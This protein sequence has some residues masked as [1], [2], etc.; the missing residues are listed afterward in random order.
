[1]P[2]YY[3]YGNDEF[4][5]EQAVH[6]LKQSL[7]LN[8]LISFTV[9]DAK[10][11]ELNRILESA[12]TV[13]FDSGNRFIWLQNP[14]AIST[15]HSLYPLLE[16][17]LAAPLSATHLVF[18]SPAPPTQLF[19]RCTQI[20]KFDRLPPWKTDQLHQWIQNTAHEYGLRLRSDSIQVLQQAIG[21]DS[22]ALHHALEKL[23]LYSNGDESQLT[24]AVVGDLITSTTATALDLAQALIE[25]NQEKALRLFAQLMSLNEPVLKILRTL[26][27]RFRLWLC[28]RS[29]LEAGMQD[30]GEIARIAE[31]RNPNQVY[32][33]RQTLRNTTS[34]RLGDGLRAILQAEFEIKSS[35]SSQQDILNLLVLKLC[36]ENTVKIDKS[37]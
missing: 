26:S 34:D 19:K 25:G 30:Q 3:F 32:F 31:I 29:L 7:K 16:A 21:N 4:A 12:L 9:Q 5:I 13:P 8:S 28:V 20:S 36:S 17:V 2:S 37:S 22:R 35:S 15:N 27:N 14:L 23:V 11:S 6:T 24:P 10:E 33:L 1:M 18:S